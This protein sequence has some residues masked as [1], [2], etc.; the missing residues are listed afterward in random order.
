MF[1]PLGR[2]IRPSIGK[3]TVTASTVS[4]RQPTYPA[5]APG[6]TPERIAR[7]LIE[8]GE[9]VMI[10]YLTWLEELEERDG[11]YGGQLHTRKA[12]L[13]S[14]EM[15]IQAAG[16]DPSDADKALAE[17]CTEHLIDGPGD[18]WTACYDLLDSIAKP[19]AIVEPVWGSMRDNGRIYW[20]PMEYHRID[21][22]W[23]QYDQDTL[24]EERFIDPALP[25][26]AP[27]DR[28][29]FLIH[30]S[31]N[32]SGLP[33]RAGVGRQC[34]WYVFFKSLALK[35][36]AA[37]VEVFGM[38]WRIGRYASAST[39]D[40]NM[41]TYRRALA[42]LGADAAVL[43]PEG[44]ELEMVDGR[45][46]KSGSGVGAGGVHDALVRFCDEQ[47][48]KVIRGQT[49][50]MDNGSSRAQGQVHADVAQYITEADG[51]LARVLQLLVTTWYAFNAPPGT[52]PGQFK[53]HT[54]PPEDLESHSKAVVPLIQVGLAVSKKQLYAKYGLEEPENEQ[55]QLG[56]LG[57]P[58]G[59]FVLSPDTKKMA[60][61]EKQADR[62]FQSQES[63]KAIKAKSDSANADRDGKLGAARNAIEQ[64]FDH[65]DDPWQPALLAIMES[66]DT[67]EEAERRLL[68][69][70]DRVDADPFVKAL[71]VEMV[72]IRMGVDRGEDA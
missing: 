14:R 68:K 48:S 32:K 20:V 27:I 66:A 4:V 11:H 6:A 41:D 36:W 58:P 62:D 1:D 59:V 51:R 22:R 50:T 54:E 37:F 12:D 57:G 42:E 13:L 3:P 29:R 17:L 72:R 24:R 34:S 10:D 40:E 53:I 63:D 52:K 64:A 19:C 71:A 8:A 35:D 44:L 38:P 25:D 15:Y 43:I 5:V 2:P 7:V 55:D 70:G 23:V 61:E 60:D 31:A 30:R 49:M 65:V 56:G 33:C 26:G 16:T 39:D 21:P 47:I 46:G 9:G 28:N 67:F 45:A 69:L 18:L